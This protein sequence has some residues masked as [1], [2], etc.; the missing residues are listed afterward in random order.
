[1]WGVDQRYSTWRGRWCRLMRWAAR[2]PSP[3]RSLMAVLWV[4]A[5]GQPSDLV[6]GR[7]ALARYRSRTRA[8]AGPGYANPSDYIARLPCRSPDNSSAT[9]DSADSARP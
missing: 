8:P 3:K 7:P 5:Q 1:M 6:R 2:K 9:G 4:D